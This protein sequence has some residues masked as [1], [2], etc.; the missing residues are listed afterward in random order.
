MIAPYTAMKFVAFLRNVNLGQRHSPTRA[1]LEAAYLQAGAG[2]A[3]S[4]MSNGTVVFT[5]AGGPEARAISER[6]RVILGTVCGMREPI[7]VSGL[8]RLARLAA[9]APFATAAAEGA[10]APCISFFTPTPRPRLTLPLSSPNGDCVVF[11]LSAGLALSL[12]R[13]VRGKTGYPTPVLEH[14]LRRP[15][16]TRA[17]ATLL[18]VIARHAIP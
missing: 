6:A 4:I 10:A 13:T 7:F 11:R 5:A 16:T 8:G 14:A 1:Q 15:V 3:A 18:R 17:W 12:T 2:A 9:E